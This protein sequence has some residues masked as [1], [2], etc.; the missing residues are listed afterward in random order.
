MTVLRAVGPGVRA[1]EMSAPAGGEA[2]GARI[3]GGRPVTESPPDFSARPVSPKSS[4]GRPFVP[5]NLAGDAWRSSES[6][7][8]LVELTPHTEF[9]T[10]PMCRA[11]LPSIRG[12]DGP[13]SPQSADV[14]G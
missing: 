11:E 12:C 13:S 6:G 2:A 14:P 7:F 5:K 4:V 3:R 10:V 9:L 8:P 1:G